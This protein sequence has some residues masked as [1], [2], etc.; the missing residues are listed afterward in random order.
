MNLR[1]FAS[2]ST[3]LMA[4]ISEKDASKEQLPKV[5]GVAWDP[6]SDCF[7]LSC[8]P[9]IYSIITKRTVASTLASIYDPM[10]WLLPLLHR[11]KVFLQYLWKEGYDWDTPL[12]QVH[13][14]SWMHIY[15]EMEG[16]TKNLPRFLC[17]KHTECI[18]VTFADA[19]VE[20]IATSIYLQ[21][22]TS[23]CLLIARGKLPSVK[24]TPT[25]PKMEL[26]AVTLALRVTNATL[27]QLRTVLRIPK[28][29]ILSDSEIV[30]SWIRR[31]PLNNVGIRIF[32]RLME[33]GSITQH[34][35]VSGHRIL[36]GHISSQHNAADCATRG[37]TQKELVD[38]FWWT[39]P[40]NLRNP[41]ET[42]STTFHEF[43]HDSSPEGEM[44][45]A[46]KDFKERTEDTE[47]SP[48]QR[49]VLM[50][51]KDELDLFHYLQKYSL[52]NAKRIVA[53]ILRYIRILVCRINARR[54]HPIKL[55]SPL[56]GVSG[57]NQAKISGT[58][59]AIAGKILIK[60]HQ[61]TTITPPILR[62]LKHLNIK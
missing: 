2:N 46:S 14:E 50:A 26:D 44:S 19:S 48:E 49:Q 3:Q 61:L 17:T 59:I 16:F 42:W 55:S 58:E 47:S 13:K 60:Q 15:S 22:Q 51:R 6:S 18:L 24:T 62:S 40:L 35:Q 8:T 34:L 10:G 52:R 45:K 7:R 37:L 56:E 23:T 28:V 38:H 33:I 12:S 30:L 39:G 43:D 36:F 25:M 53:I 5:L 31:R 54:Q 29:F 32:N 57:N 20:A 1:E 21:S 41:P 4:K 9:K 27:S 11:A